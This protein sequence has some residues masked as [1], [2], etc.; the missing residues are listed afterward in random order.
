MNDVLCV[1]DRCGGFCASWHTILQI[2]SSTLGVRN[3]LST[4]L[5][6]C[7][8]ALALSTAVEANA[9]QR[10]IIFVPGT[11]ATSFNSTL[12]FQ[13]FAGSRVWLDLTGTEPGI[14]F[15]LLDDA[16]VEHYFKLKHS[17]AS[18]SANPQMV[19]SSGESLRYH[20]ST[21]QGYFNGLVDVDS[22]A[23]KPHESLKNA[24]VRA[25]YI[26]GMNLFALRYEWH[27]EWDLAC[28]RLT[29][30]VNE[31]L[32][33]SGSDKV[34]L[35]GHSQGTQVI[36]ACLTDYQRG[37]NLHV[38]GVVQLAPPTSGGKPAMEYANIA[39]SG[40]G[41]GIDL[42]SLYGIV[43]AQLSGNTVRA[44]AR[45]AP[46]LYAMLPDA[47]YEQRLKAQFPWIVGSYAEFKDTY[48]VVVNNP[49]VCPD[50]VK[51]FV[52][53]ARLYPP[54][55][56][57]P[58]TIL[59]HKNMDKMFD[60]ILREYVKDRKT[61]WN[62]QRN[63]T[64]VPYRVIVATGKQ[65]PVQY[66]VHFHTYNFIGTPVSCF[67][68]AVS[69]SVVYGAGDGTV[70]EIATQEYR[71][72]GPV[73]RIVFNGN[74]ASTADCDESDH[75][76]FIKSSCA[77]RLVNLYVTPWVNTIGRVAS[78]QGAEAFSRAAVHAE[79]DS[80]N[81]DTASPAEELEKWEEIAGTQRSRVTGQDYRLT[82]F[83][84]PL[85]RALDVRQR[86]QTF[87]YLHVNVR[88]NSG[89]SVLLQFDDGG[90]LQQEAELL[91]TAS[92]EGTSLAEIGVR[93]EIVPATQPGRKML[94]VA[95]YTPIHS[96]GEVVDASFVVNN[97][98]YIVVKTQEINTKTGY[99][100]KR[101]NVVQGG[102]NAVIEFTPAT[103]ESEG[104]VKVNG[105][106]TSR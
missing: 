56:S 8:L 91:S 46:A 17:Q 87:D 16:E 51:T 40:L 78:Q 7:L 81:E 65:M 49:F 50:D 88:T 34:F 92:S 10:P 58:A 79:P 82:S 44:I 39:T 83:Y 100:P 33:A 76:G 42:G 55:A 69:S 74:L 67:Y 57:T 96:T 36:D 59:F 27:N 5:K 64:D 60:P 70:P 104:T 23:S 77:T 2:N 37:L 45:R 73:S 3:M 106:L 62:D 95:F 1:T 72:V 9:A 20:G 61:R 14:P 94:H 26:L 24:L 13:N 48:N 18:T 43:G 86:G 97:V 28:S 30:L 102:K 89:H 68:P 75:L 31:A 52:G 4:L 54:A 90:T 15:D 105:V 21:S 32:T 84:I 80:Q 66:S 71:T 99:G 98:S 63:F 41:E 19:T 53:R 103:P 47:D 11:M 38:A 12:S 85:D 29:D 35:I 101:M 25:G 93:T 6:L 22:P